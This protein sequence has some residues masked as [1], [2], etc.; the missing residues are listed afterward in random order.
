MN[1][2][3]RG[4]SGYQD[5]LS[6]RQ[7][8]GAGAASFLGLTMPQLLFGSTQGGS[9][10]SVVLLWMAGGQSHID[11]W[12][13]K[14]GRETNGPIA[15]IPTAAKGIKISEHLPLVARQFADISLIRSLTSNEGS[16]ERATYLMHTGYAPL[17][18]FA[19]AALGSTVVKEI[20]GR[21][22]DLPAYVSIN[23]SPY[24]LG[25]G[26]L[27]SRFAP[28]IVHNST[29]P[30]QNLT[31]HQDMTEKRFSG[32][33]TLLKELDKNFAREHRRNNVISDYAKFYKSALRMMHSP[34]V[35]AF[36]L[37]AEPMAKRTAYGMNYFG[38]GVLLA[39]R[40]VEAGTRFVE[41]QL[42]G[43]DTHYENFDSVATLS[44]RLDKAMDALLND[45]RQTRRLE[46]TLIV[47]TGEFGRTPQIN[48]DN[49]RDHWPRVWSAVMAGGGVQGGRLI[50][51]S[52]ADGMEPATRPVQVGE[53]HAT[54][55]KAIGVDWKQYNKAP[56][57]RPIRVVKNKNLQPIY[58]LF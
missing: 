17:S 13:P 19:H 55:C 41:V 56:D 12:D 2:E 50:G 48:K 28:F 44:S 47:L 57:G 21:Q 8:L 46:R 7:F 5:M 36:D 45:L 29:E 53:L 31:Y 40:L 33:L 25:A 49:G 52:D 16:H 9:A 37:E 14:P 43:W 38:Q 58:E 39:R 20:G 32:R 51:E 18:T 3:C 26:F 54:I 1:D 35:K 34:A 23:G 22:R 24:N 6:R 42:G 10:D 4:C 15:A 27:G 30:A 11:T